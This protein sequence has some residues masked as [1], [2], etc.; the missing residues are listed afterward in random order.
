M[1]SKA[2]NPSYPDGLDIE[3]V[4]IVRLPFLAPDP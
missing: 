1:P 3:Q 4:Q 2:E